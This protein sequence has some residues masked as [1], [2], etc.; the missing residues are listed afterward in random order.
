MRRRTLAGE[1][2]QLEAR[3]ATMADVTAAYASA[4]QRIRAEEALTGARR[5]PIIALTANAMAE[6]V[7]ECMDAG[8]DGYVSKPIKADLLAKE[9]ERCTTDVAPLAHTA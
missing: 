5:T 2:A 3:L 9:I 8:M 7:T 1:I 4:T 6:A